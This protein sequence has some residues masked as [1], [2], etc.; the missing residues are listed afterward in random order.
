[1]ADSTE[2]EI[3]VVAAVADEGTGKFDPRRDERPMTNQELDT[4]RRE[5]PGSPILTW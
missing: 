5:N 3:V 2:E 1:M 4:F